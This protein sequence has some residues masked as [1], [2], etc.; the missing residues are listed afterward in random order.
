[1]IQ[2][3]VC[4]TC[5]HMTDDWSELSGLCGFCQRGEDETLYERYREEQDK[6]YP[7]RIS[8]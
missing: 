3:D 2:T 1:M 5:G 7:P 6:D 8:S 4:I